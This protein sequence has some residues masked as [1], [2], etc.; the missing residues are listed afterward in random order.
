MATVIEVGNL[1]DD[2]TPPLIMTDRLTLRPTLSSDR[3][4]FI[5]LQSSSTV[6]RYLV[7]FDH[8]DPTR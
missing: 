5:D 4:S 8:R 3:A 7:L 1:N 2:V 6:R